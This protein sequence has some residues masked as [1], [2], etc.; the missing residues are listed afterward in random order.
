MLQIALVILLLAA[1]ATAQTATTT[2]PSKAGKTPS[3]AATLKPLPKGQTRV[4]EALVMKVSGVAQARASRKAKWRK[5]KVNDALKPGVLIRTG[6]KS[7]VALRVGP[8]ATLIID[9]QTRVAIPQIVQNGDTLKTRVGVEFGRVDVKAS[10]IGLA[11]DFAVSTP[12]STLAVRGTTF[13]ISWDAVEG[14][15]AQGVAGNR[16]RA[17]EMAYARD[18]AALSK[19]D[20]SDDGNP[21]PAIHAFWATY[22][23][24]LQGAITPEVLED[25]RI[26]PT[27]LSKVPDG[28]GLDAARK[29]LGNKL[30]ALGGQNPPTT[31]PPPLTDGQ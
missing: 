28:S 30:E 26:Q 22:I 7:M 5:L 13:R 20:A 14:T 11:I 12:T 23:I 21:L 9:R 1:T 10:R 29:A 3:A 4:F 27:D 8:N 16:M 31:E 19:S 6:R 25:P 17:I 24:P 2:T 15:R 18:M